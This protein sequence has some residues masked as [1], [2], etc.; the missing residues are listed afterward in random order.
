MVEDHP[1]TADS[2]VEAVRR[3]NRLYT[4]R[5]GAL[6]AA[7]LDTPFSLT[8]A[9]VLYELAHRDDLTLSVL[10]AEL[11]LDPGYLSRLLRALE[12]RG[13]VARRRA[14]GDSRRQLLRL[15]PKGA[16]AFADL[17][18]RTRDE[19]GGMLRELP[20]EARARLVEALGAVE[21]LLG[22]QASS[23]RLRPHRHGDIGW[24]VQRHGELYREEYGYDERFEAL[25]AE[26]AARFIQRYDARRERC[27]IAE[28][29]GVRVGAV[30]LVRKSEKTAQLRLLL[31]E[32]A[33]RGLG[34]GKRLVGECIAFARQAG[35]RRLVLWTQSELAAA[36]GMYVKAGFR[37][38][39]REPHRS[40]G[41]RLVGEYWALDL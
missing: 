12:R 37:L 17:E 13:L 31:V 7:H 2:R 29:D 30:F 27:W 4:R 9:R 16:R 10:A 32:P 23:V 40:F 15:T 6:Q 20:G 22:G 36:R 41:K 21:N 8:E 18:A 11:R 26:I 28:R 25:V 1:M 3:F 35:Y 5:I 19:V 14:A 24:V 34:L 38:V 39:R 33:A